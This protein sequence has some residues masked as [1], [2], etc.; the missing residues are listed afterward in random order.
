MNKKFLVFLT[1]FIA[2]SLML[3][4]C[5]PDTAPSAELPT[6]TGKV[7]LHT[8]A[9][10]HAA[11]CLNPAYCWI[12]YNLW[13]VTYDTLVDW[14][15]IGEPV[16]GRL[17]ESWEISADGLIWTFH[18]V[19]LGNISFHDGT[20]LTSEDVAW[21]INYVAYNPG[22]SWLLWT[23]VGE[24]FGAVATD[25]RTVVLTLDEATNPDAFLSSLV[26]VYILPRHIWEQYDWTI[27]SFENE[28]VI[29]TGPFMFNEWVPGQHLILDANPNYWG[30]KPS[31]D[32]I[33][34]QV[35]TT[36]DAQ[37][38]ALDSGEV[39]HITDVPAN[40][41]DQ[42][43]GNPDI[44]VISRPPMYEYHLFFNMWDGGITHP[45]LTDLRVRQAIAHAIDKEQLLDVVF[46]GRGVA[47]NSMWDGGARFD[48]W[49][50]PDIKS[51][52]FDLEEAK[53]ILENAG[54][55]DTD[56]DGIR[57]MND[58]SGQP[59]T[60]RF[61]FDAGQANHLPYAETIANWLSD[62][63]IG[64][65]LEALE[66]LTLTEA[67]LAG[68]FDLILYLYGFEW[69]PEYQL[70]SL[71]CLGVDWGINFPGYCNA[72]FDELYAAQHLAQERQE[73]REYVYEA[74]RLVHNEVPWIQLVHINSYEAYNN[75][76]F[77]FTITDSLWPGWGWY[78]VQGI[79]PQ[80]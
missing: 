27:F 64:T 50:P 24:N 17:A 58:G 12:P 78:G 73:R 39:N 42:L 61:Y 10:G 52:S 23:K 14:G 34:I 6:D 29:G 76:L 45:A 25:D 37:V 4:A 8:T 2:L 16:R 40:F 55:K 21:A 13:E 38:L 32:Q 30:G 77:N 65:E 35:Y 57:E 60:F 63:G 75:Q 5:G 3:A 68:D 53:G 48:Y 33:I 7:V 18:L 20:P 80:K 1:L 69:D 46:Q 44:T 51:Y 26:Y 62:I 47:S 28:D 71:T 56:G 59:L 74:Q 70:L 11:D 54:Y 36:P 49:A 31:V 67:A 41:V 22:L 19:D 66:S 79:E 72:D 43:D 9:E 15:G